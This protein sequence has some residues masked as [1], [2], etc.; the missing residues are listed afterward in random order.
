[1]FERIKSMLLVMI[2]WMIGKIEEPCILL[3]QEFHNRQT[4]LIQ[5]SV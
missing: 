2:D 1:M 4:E 5:I 3:E